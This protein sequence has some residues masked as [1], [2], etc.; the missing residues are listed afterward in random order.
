[1]RKSKSRLEDSTHIQGLE[2]FNIDGN[3]LFQDLTKRKFID[4]E[5]DV[6]SMVIA[7]DSKRALAICNN[8]DEE[9]KL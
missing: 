1:M 4:T 3:D 9:F 7:Y 5:I 8:K 2:A 6:V